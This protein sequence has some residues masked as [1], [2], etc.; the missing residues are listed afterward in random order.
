M[1]FDSVIGS[2][3]MI[4]Y[5]AYLILSL[6]PGAK[7][8]SFRSFF[9]LS[10]ANLRDRLKAGFRARKIILD[11]RIIRLGESDSGYFLKSRRLAAGSLRRGRDA[12]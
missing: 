7:G 2:G 12:Q 9:H 6:R 10:N 11:G 5:V 4:G 3:A 8:Q 1:T